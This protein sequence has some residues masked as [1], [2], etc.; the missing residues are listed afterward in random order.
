MATS[1]ISSHNPAEPAVLTPRS[2]IKALLASIDDDSDEDVTSRVVNRNNG[3]EAPR[4]S[5]KQSENKEVLPGSAADLEPIQLTPRSKVKAMM[6]ELDVDSDD[7]IVSRIEDHNN[8]LGDGV[9]LPMPLGKARNA[10]GSTQEVD[11]DESARSEVVRPRGKL[12]ARLMGGGPGTADR[13]EKILDADTSAYERVKQQLLR[14]SPAEISSDDN[15]ARVEKEDVPVRRLLLKKRKKPVSASSERASSPSSSLPQQKSSPRRSNSPEL[16]QPAQRLESRTSTP[17]LFVTPTKPMVV[18][19]S[20]AHNKGGDSDS[21]LPDEPQANARFL[22]LVAKKRKEREE[23]AAVEEKKRAERRKLEALMESEDDSG[24]ED[25]ERKGEKLSQRPARKASK[26]ALEEMHRE[27]QR[28]SRNMQLAHQA[29][30]KRKITKESLLARFN[31]RGAQSRQTTPAAIPQPQASSTT[32][33]SPRASDF[34]GVKEHNT[35]PTSPLKPDTDIEKNEHAILPESGQSNPL[36][37][38]EDIIHV[39]THEKDEVPGL[40]HAQSPEPRNMSPMQLSENIKQVQLREEDEFPGLEHAINESLQDLNKGKGKAIDHEEDELPDLG[41]MMKY[42]T[43]YLGK[44]KE[45]AFNVDEDEAPDMWDT[46]D[47]P[48]QT[49]DK[50]KGKAVDYGPLEQAEALRKS[51]KAVFTQPP[52]RVRPPKKITQ[53]QSYGSD[54]DDLLE[55]IPRKESR[56]SMLDVFEKLP[57]KNPNDERPLQ[58]LRALANLTSPSKLKDKARASMGP[59]ELQRNLQRRARQQAAKERAEKIQSLKD[60]GIIIQ[61]TEERHRDQADVEDLLEKARQEAVELTKKEKAAVQKEHREDGMLVMDTSDEDEDYKDEEGD[62]DSQKADDEEVAELQL[63]GSEDE[64][65]DEALDVEGTDDEEEEDETEGAGNLGGLIANEASEDSNEE[66]DEDERAHATEEDE[67]EDQLP[68]IQK[69]RRTRVSH[70]VVDD[71]IE[72]EDDEIEPTATD[73]VKKP[74]V[75]KFPGFDQAPLGLTQIFEAT[76][77]ETQAEDDSATQGMSLL[78][79]MP[80]PVFP[81]IE[82]EPEIMVPD[83]QEQAGDDGGMKSDIHPSPNQPQNSQ[84]QA[85]PSPT[86]FSQIPDPTQDG[87]FETSSLIGDR[88]VSVPPSTVDTVLIPAEHDPEPMVLKK[89][90]RLRRRTEA[91]QVLSDA[92][93]ESDVESED[94]EQVENRTYT[95]T[96]N[97][98]DFMKKARKEAQVVEDFNKKKSEAKGMV[99]EQAQESE[100]EYAGL[101]GASDEDSNAEED[102]E[103]RKMIDK[104]EVNVDERKLAALYAYVKIHKLHSTQQGTNFFAVNA[105]SHRMKKLSQSS[106]KISTTVDSAANEA[107]NSIYPTQTMKLNAAAPSNVVN[108]P[109]CAKPSSRTRKSAKSPKIPRNLPSCVPL[110]IAKMMKTMTSS[111]NQK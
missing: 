76:M 109:R 96:E 6:A 79:Q 13:E 59:A 38:S 44:G 12:A 15:I 75:P 9:E 19:P 70:V 36:Q 32:A 45:R 29:K 99:E 89:R 3:L 51:K 61:T 57:K 2:K 43:K 68:V 92:A 104:G 111:R 10:Q 74:I 95:I 14:K 107:P 86:Q 16:P 33:S 46:L 69:K 5:P 11:S 34:E 78:S 27:T 94:G 30:T 67:I 72:D 77:A 91:I 53:V 28:M 22:A 26:K 87:G 17:G 81:E 90:G 98:F 18:I 54:S 58:T 39:Q 83:S 40:E 102:E 1:P 25:G 93:T 42:P 24:V 73:P 55:I 85:P 48:V 62:E 23:K 52:I 65:D 20:N 7:D 108:L 100:D 106:T 88:F 64:A 47:E 21:S 31:F 82:R 60:R 37:A 103:D 84:D 63:S 97:A 71:D 50:G 4:K 101:G 49:L 8:G 80:D 56:R 105:N 66:E 110:K 41:D 35:P